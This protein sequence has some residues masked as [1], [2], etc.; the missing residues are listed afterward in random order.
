MSMLDWQATYG[1]ATFDP[2]VAGGTVTSLTL[3]AN[4]ERTGQPAAVAAATALKPG[5]F[6]FVIP[7]TLAAGRYWGTVVFTPAAGEPASTDR[8]IRVDLPTGSGLVT[9][10]EA[11]ADHAGIPL[12]LTEA[13]RDGLRTA[14]EDAQADVEAYLARSLVP[15]SAT[16]H[17]VR[18]APGTDLG[19]WQAWAHC[20]PDDDFAVDGWTVL[21]DGTYDVRLLVGLDGA[22][23][24]PIR[25]FVTAHAA[26]AIR[27]SPGSGG[28][29][30]GRR[31]SSLSAEGQSIS[32]EAAPSAGQAG[33]LP[34]L[35]TLDGYR[36]PPVYVRPRPAAAPWPY[37]GMTS[38]WR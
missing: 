22:A 26:E 5:T 18:P 34:V 33:A 10:P 16:L 11:V 12:P 7:D 37:G 38:L 1:G 14:I 24:R 9:S 3:H 17:G 32:Y 4:P 27:N 25:R 20:G 36:Q 8:T 23:E 6:R 13:Q 28:A 29:A 19:M 21:P 30:G 2:T 15:R 35:V 31:V